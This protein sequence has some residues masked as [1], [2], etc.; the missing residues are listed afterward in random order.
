MYTAPGR[1]F[2]KVVGILYVIFA[3]LGILLGLLGLAGTAA[4]GALGASTSVL[5][6]LYVIMLL[7][8][9]Y[10]LFLGIIGIKHCNDLRKASFVRICGIVDIVLRSLIVVWGGVTLGFAGI[11]LESIGLVLPI[12]FLVGAS[13]N[14]AAAAS[15]QGTTV[16]GE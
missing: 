3:G 11:V 1:G 8:S 4:L 15:M 5:T 16:D 13:K 14:V 10:G 9:G 7:S 6:L 2:L 12:L